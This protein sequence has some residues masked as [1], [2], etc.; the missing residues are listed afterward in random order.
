MAELTVART[1]AR[2]LFGA[3]KDLDKLEVIAE[4][5]KDMEQVLGNETELVR[6]LSM[7]SIPQ[8]EKIDALRDIFSGMVSEEF[9]I[10][11]CILIEKGRLSQFE[12]IARE[13]DAIR[14]EEEGFSAGVIYSSIPLTQD[15]LE[16][17]EEETGRL[18][19]EKVR[20]TNEI[21]E[22]L[23]GGIKILINGKMIDASVKTRVSAL[24]DAII[25]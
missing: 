19:R 12:R 17:F 25:K 16:K 13:F 8:S 24:A 5:L 2:A 11:I 23:L 10:F 21:D 18:L 20:L 15:R 7:P 9:L 14:N 6:F 1:Y 4:D 3:A 22:S